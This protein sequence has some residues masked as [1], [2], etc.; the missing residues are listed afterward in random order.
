MST[1]WAVERLRPGP[2]G[3]L[4]SEEPKAWWTGHNAHGVPIC[5]PDA[6]RAY[7]WDSPQEALDAIVD[8]RPGVAERYRVVPAPGERKP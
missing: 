5:D 4:R 7:R 3:E 1:G 8:L 2:E 6:G